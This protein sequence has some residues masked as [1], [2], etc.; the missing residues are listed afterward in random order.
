MW[1]LVSAKPIMDRRIKLKVRQQQMQ[2][3]LK[4]LEALNKVK[5]QIDNKSPMKPRFLS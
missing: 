5:G 3:R 1:N 4:H 2:A